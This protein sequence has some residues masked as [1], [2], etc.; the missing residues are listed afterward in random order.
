MPVKRALRAE[1]LPTDGTSVWGGDIWVRSIMRSNMF[2]EFGHV[3]HGLMADGANVLR[4]VAII[5]SH[6]QNLQERLKFS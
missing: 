1:N 4:G 3:S 6:W 5:H 2:G